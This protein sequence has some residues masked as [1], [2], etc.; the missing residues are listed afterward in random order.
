LKSRV[1]TYPEPNESVPGANSQKADFRT[2]SARPED[3]SGRDSRKLIDDAKIIESHGTPYI[4]TMKGFILVNQK[5]F[6]ARFAAEHLILHEGRERE[7]YMYDYASGAW[8]M[9]TLDAIKEMFSNDCPT[10]SNG[11]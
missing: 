8:V 6:V 2:G 7:F 10:S 11:G 3:K 9:Q 1:K 5:Y 4:K